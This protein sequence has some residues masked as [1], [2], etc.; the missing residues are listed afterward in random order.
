LLG[1]ATPSDPPT[2]QQWQF[3]VFTEAFT[4]TWSGIWMEYVPLPVPGAEVPSLKL[5]S[6]YK[7]RQTVAVRGD[8]RVVAWREEQ[9]HMAS[10]GGPLEPVVTDEQEFLPSSFRADNGAMAVDNSFT[11]SRAWAG[12]AG[13]RFFDAEVWTRAGDFRTRCR[14]VYCSP[15]PDEPFSI[16]KM[17]VKKE[18]RGSKGPTCEEPQLFGRKGIG[19]YDRTCKAASDWEIPVQGGLSVAFPPEIP[20][21]GK[22]AISM[23]WIA[24]PMRYQAD[25]L[26]NRPDG[27][28]ESLQ[29]TEIGSADSLRY[30]L[31]E[32]P[33]AP[34]A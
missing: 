27:T 13:E 26:F 3:N 17:V 31:N 6:V 32:G 24:G 4:G 22:G 20:E 16:A 29:L 21:D 15:R 1:L 12:E 5:I 30:V 23:D 10:D 18:V 33:A 8:E 2:P 25:R 34:A 11:M 9:L 7:G 14:F 28:L 19:I